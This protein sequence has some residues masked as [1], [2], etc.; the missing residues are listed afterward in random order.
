MSY[1][2]SAIVGIQLDATQYTRSYPTIWSG[3][4]VTSWTDNPAWVFYDLCTNS[5]YGLGNYIDPKFLDVFQLYSIAKYCDELIDDGFGGKEPRYTCNLYIQ[6]REEAYKV[7]SNLAALFSSIVYWGVGTIN[8]LSDKSTDTTYV[9]TNANVEDGAFNYSSSS[10]KSTHTVALV[11]YIDKTNNYKP[12]IEYVEDTEGVEKFGI[13]EVE[14]VAYGCTSRGQAHRLGRRMLLTEKL[15]GELVSFR[16][17]LGAAYCRPGAVIKIQDNTIGVGN[18]SGGRILDFNT[19]TITLDREITLE[20]G[21]TYQLSITTKNN[22]VKT[23]AI[24]N[25]LNTTNTITISNSNDYL[26][27]EAAQPMLGSIW[28]LNSSEV[29]NYSYW[30]VLSL[31]EA[32]DL[33]FEISCIKYEPT[34][35]WQIETG[36]D[37]AINKPLGLLDLEVP[38]IPL[39][40]LNPKW[41]AVNGEP[42]EID[43]IVLVESLYRVGKADI[44]TRVNIAWQDMKEASEYRVRYKSNNNNW[45]T[46]N[47]GVPYFELNNAQDGDVYKFELYAV[48]VLGRLSAPTTLTHTVV[49]KLAP[50]QDVTGLVLTRSSM[51]AVLKFNEV[52]DIDLAGYEVRYYIGTTVKT[53][54]QSTALVTGLTSNR[55]EILCNALAAQ[56]NFLV[57]AYDTTG[58]W[59]LTAATANFTITVPSAPSV[60]SAIVGPNAVIKVFPAA[61]GATQLDIADY[62]I[63]H[64]DLN[65]GQTTNTVTKGKMDNNIIP[66]DYAVRTYYTRVTDI[67]GNISSY[68]SNTI[69]VTTLSAVTS[70]TK[71]FRNSKVY[72]NWTPPTLTATNVPISYYKV[73]KDNTLEANKIAEVTDATFDTIIDWEIGT[74]RNF[75]VVPIDTRGPTWP[76]ASNTYSVNTIIPQAVE[77]VPGQ[78][79]QV[80]TS[81]LVDW[82]DLDDV[83]YDASPKTTLP[84]KH[85]EVRLNGADYDSG[86]YL[87]VTVSS[88]FYIP[89]SVPGTMTIRVKGYDTNNT[90]GIESITTYVHT[91]P[92]VVTNLTYTFTQEFA[93]LTWSPPASIALPIDKYEIRYAGAFV[94]FTYGSTFNIKA[95]WTGARNFTVAAIDTAG[96][97]GTEETVIVTV[98]IPTTPTIGLSFIGDSVQILI[99]G[100]TSSLPITTYEVRRGGTSWGV[101]DTLISTTTDTTLIHQVNYTSTTAMVYRVKAKD[102]LGNVG[103]EGTSSITVSPPSMS[104]TTAQAVDNNVLLYWSATKGSLPIDAFE[105]RKGP[106]WD[107]VTTVSIGRKDGGF[108]TI[109]ETNGGTYTYWIA[110][111]DSAGNYGT[112]V[113]RAVLVAQP[114][115]YIFRYKH[116]STWNSFSPDPSTVI[117]VSKTNCAVDTVDNTIVGPIYLDE[118]WATHFSTRAWNSIQ[119]QITAG[120]SVYIQP[121]N[122]V[123]SSDYIETI[124]YTTDTASAIA[125]T[126]VSVSYSGIV[127]AGSPVVKC[128]ISYKTLSTDSWSSEIE[129]NEIFATNFRHIKVRINIAATTAVALY[130]IYSMSV[131]LDAKIKNDSGALYCLAEDAGGTQAVWSYGTTFADIT[132]ITT[133]ARAIAI[134]GTITHSITDT[135]CTATCTSHNLQVG[136]K[137][138]ATFTGGTPPPAAT[139]TVTAKTATTFTFTIPSGSGTGT[140]SIRIPVYTLYDFQ[141]SPSPTGFKIL[142]YDSA[143]ARASGYASWAVD[144]Y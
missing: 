124:Q 143:G 57:K 10:L 33:I 127:I 64:T 119:D 41:T 93:K 46:K 144:G 66:I 92:A 53:W 123:A 94:G 8:I 97:Y 39:R 129:A 132:S 114:P 58:N 126:K 55:V 69:T 18:L 2:N 139:Y 133:Q 78:V 125:S 36:V 54:E 56:H 75:I 71:K 13:K 96:N 142:L 81:L 16:T 98:A 67:A 99:S 79:K 115:D 38:K 82:Y 101:G 12:A 103:A 22:K 7:I 90:E 111:I 20:A 77:F 72:L 85:Y 80:G 24:N 19:T 52:T 59:S 65:W 107:D 63:R 17:G 6:T 83:R 105:I 100:V 117:A 27:L 108:T 116:D 118:T 48:N 84:I 5:R 91:V 89:L 60:T 15:E 87:G 43:N 45:V 102:M 44:A 137:F 106:S 26:G 135:T 86:T 138:Y 74:A 68:V 122:T 9:F 109:F 95:T 50:P 128:Y 61:I 130:K 1:P 4:F 62:T 121:S 3:G 113:P 28:V 140:T 37:L 104:N 141:D 134:G 31:K 34:K 21:I 110:P 136:D 29:V 11:S 47:I 23:I 131:K 35:N 32:D 112:P 51:T 120:Y 49:G 70:I 76:G 14:V 73:F 88:S 40:I 25:T 30:R 42:T